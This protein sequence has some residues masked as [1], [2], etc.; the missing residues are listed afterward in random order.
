MLICYDP[1]EYENVSEY[2]TCSFGC[3]RS[4]SYSSR[5]RSPEEILAIKAK[6]Q[7]EEEDRILARAEAIKATRGVKGAKE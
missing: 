2:R 6:R 7:R 3:C 5:R 1:D 4:A